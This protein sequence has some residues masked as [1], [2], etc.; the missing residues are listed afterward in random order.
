MKLSIEEF[1]NWEHKSI[2]LLGMSGV[3]KT[4]LAHMLRRS[5]WFHFSGDYR[6]GTRYL[7]E[8]ILDNIKSQAMQVEFLRNLLRNDSIQIINNITV[9]NL[10]PVS[11]FL[12]KLGNPELGGLS[13][14]EFKRRQQ[15]H[16]DA[17]IAAMRDVPD[18]II[19]AKEIYGYQHF[20]N[21]AGGSVCELEDE[22]TIKIL[23]E[24]SLILYIKASAKEEEEL[25]RRAESD[26]KPLYYRE[27]FLDEELKIYMEKYQ[28]PY[29]AMIDPDQFVRWMFPRLFN[30]RIPRYDAIAREYGYTITTQELSMVSTESDFLEL[31]ENA[32]RREQ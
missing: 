31:I 23:D 18:F 5:D 26:P 24:H 7:D 11:S 8:P 15:L 12:G 32:I 27:A 4:R 16:L 10:Q 2:T 17:E 22:E 29:V 28:L 6:I 13:L 9:D 1:R 20:I 21:D 3:G 19:K 25:I 30:S 14:T